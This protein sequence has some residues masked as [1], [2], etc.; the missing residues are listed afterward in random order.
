MTLTCTGS[1]VPYTVGMDSVTQNLPGKSLPVFLQI[2]KKNRKH[3][4]DPDLDSMRPL[5]AYP[6]SWSGFAI[7]IRIQEGKMAQKK[8][9][10]LRNFIFWSAGC[11]FLRAEGFSYTV[12]WTSSSI[13][14]VNCNLWSKKER[15]NFSCIFQIFGHE[16]PGSVSGSWFT[17]NAGSGFN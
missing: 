10:Q 11:S 15:K 1:P 3:F 17:W 8:R 6:L 2:P 13:G 7:P 14:K 16:N 9:K 12:T 4:V 5:D